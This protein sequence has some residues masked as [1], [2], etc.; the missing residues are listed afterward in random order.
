M[1]YLIILTAV[2]ISFASFGQADLL[3]KKG[4]K[5]IYKGKVYKSSYLGS[6][7]SQSPEAYKLF[8]SGKKKTRRAKIYGL[9]GLGLIGVGFSSI[10]FQDFN[11][12][13][14]GGGV[15]VLGVISG[16]IAIF[17]AIGGHR[18]LKK[19]LKTFNYDM[20]ERHGYQSDTALAFGVTHNG[21]GFVLQF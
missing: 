12:A 14:I 20:I 9:T 21:L 11:I 8:K 15:I 18:R 19:A 2:L 3:E 17:S 1:K 4:R 13:V 7:Y 6:I 16:T 10:Q 5:Y